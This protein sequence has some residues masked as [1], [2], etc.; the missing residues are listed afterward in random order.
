MTRRLT[1]QKRL[2]WTG[3]DR[4]PRIRSLNTRKVAKA[5]LEFGADSSA[6][7]CSGDFPDHVIGTGAPA[8]VDDACARELSEIVIGHRR[9]VQNRDGEGGVIVIHR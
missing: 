3:I 2:G 6:K 9:R 1:L 4:R 8:D 5:L 7:D